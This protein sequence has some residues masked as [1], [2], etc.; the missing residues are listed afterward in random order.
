MTLVLAT[1]LLG[2]CAQSAATT[3]TATPT[4]A[5][6]EERGG[7]G[8]PPA[9]PPI[10][11]I[12]AWIQENAILLWKPSVMRAGVYQFDVENRGL[13][14][15]DFTIVQW[16]GNPRGLPQRSGRVLLQTVEL[17]ARSPVLPPDGAYSIVA[18]LSIGGQF[19]ILSGEGTDYG[20]GMLTTFTVGS[21]SARPEP[22]PPP[23]AED[24]SSVGVYLLDGGVFVSRPDVDSG[25]VTAHVQN[26]GPSPHDLLVIQWRGDPRALPTDD[27]SDV[28]L[29]ALTVLA[30]IPTLSPGETATVTFEA[31]DEMGYA[32]IS[33]LPGDY[34]A[35]MSAQVV[36]D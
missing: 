1:L 19:V 9:S 27:E 34:E 30:R 6:G 15:H 20:E 28:L 3:I 14:A 33:S 22:V 12:P 25:E 21:G 18:D 36:V 7:A 23:S 29:D 24:D 13:L 2:A 4:A 11:V 8:V 16:P 35:G 5:L 32:L 26:L 17:V 10:E 31:A